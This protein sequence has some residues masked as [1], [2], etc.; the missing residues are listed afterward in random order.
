MHDGGKFL[1]AACTSSSHKIWGRGSI[2]ERRLVNDGDDSCTL[3][4]RRSPS[5][6]M[7]QDELYYVTL[8]EDMNKDVVEWQV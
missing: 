5:A 3:P 2:D 6:C 4:L 7:K 1:P 8:D